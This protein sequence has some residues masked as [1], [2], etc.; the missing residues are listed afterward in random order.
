MDGKMIHAVSVALAFIGLY[1]VVLIWKKW[2]NMD[3]GL[4]KAR[5]F[6]DEGFL[7]RNWFYIFLSGAVLT[8]HQFLGILP[9]DFLPGSGLV[10]QMS[11]I[12]ESVALVFLVVLAYEW[13]VLIYKK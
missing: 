1:L 13:Y 9:L 6:L 12:L 4:I 3:K 5:V 11:S 10:M 2:R 8:V 7:A